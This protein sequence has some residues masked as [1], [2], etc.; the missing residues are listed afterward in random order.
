[1]FSKN[2]G[3]NSADHFFSWAAFGWTKRTL[4]VKF[5]EGSFLKDWGKQH[6]ELLIQIHV[7][8]VD[9]VGLAIAVTQQQGTTSI[10]S[11]EFTR[12]PVTRGIMNC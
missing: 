6:C 11:C 12:D 5:F 9:S 8:G 10:Q 7:T 2:F 1:M 3:A 4:V